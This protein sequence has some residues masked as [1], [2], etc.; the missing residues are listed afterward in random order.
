MALAC[1]QD[2]AL[3]ARSYIVPPR[4]PFGASFPLVMERQPHTCD[5]YDG[6]H[7]RMAGS[8]NRSICQLFS[9]GVLMQPE[10]H[11]R[12]VVASFLGDC[13]MRRIPCRAI[14]IGAN[15]GWVS[16]MMLALGVTSLTSVEPQADLANALRDTVRLN[17]WDRSS[18]RVLNNAVTLDE[19]QQGQSISLR[20]G[21]RLYH[22][23]QRYR[24]KNYTV[25]L[26]HVGA[27]F[28]ELWYDFVKIDVDGIDGAL[29]K[30][31]LGQLTAGRLRVDTIFV[32][33]TG[34][35][36][37]TLWSFQ[38]NLGYHAYILD[39][40]DERRILN[41]KGQDIANG[42]RPFAPPLD[43][44][45]EERY[46]QRFLR[47]VYYVSPKADL[48]AWL[49]ITSPRAKERGFVYHG[50]N[51]TGPREIVFTKQQLAE[52]ELHELIDDKSI[53]PGRA[54]GSR[55]KTPK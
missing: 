44:A 11:T 6:V 19:Q 17:C 2:A 16:G 34:C 46:A 5:L 55:K 36:H 9:D 43:E 47:H 18:V 53:R 26:V 35:D 24:G 50:R 37:E 20:Y 27:V 31:L 15:N 8:G 29:M 45:L 32:E 33:C 28:S 49:R 48:E 14:D 13:R 41:A 30:W 23:S 38:H 25:P 42:F 40:T 21:W 12:Q 7:V 22:W 1:A 51:P 54:V 39:N 3:L 10:V 52:P 4:F